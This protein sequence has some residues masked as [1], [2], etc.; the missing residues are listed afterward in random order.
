[1]TNSR[2]DQLLGTEQQLLL[3]C[4]CSI[5]SHLISSYAYMSWDPAKCYV[6][7]AIF[8]QVTVFFQDFVHCRLS[9][10]QQPAQQT[11]VMM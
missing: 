1:M 8:C 4:P 9:G 3:G 6:S 11:V 7:A 2:R 5:V 10:Y